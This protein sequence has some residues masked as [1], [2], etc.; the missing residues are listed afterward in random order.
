MTAG[1]AKYCRE[2]SLESAEGCS[3]TNNGS[4]DFGQRAGS[5]SLCSSGSALIPITSFRT[6]CCY[7]YFKT[8]KGIKKFGNWLFPSYYGEVVG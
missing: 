8:K 4:F 6:C 5:S 1:C 7:C 2:K 3:L